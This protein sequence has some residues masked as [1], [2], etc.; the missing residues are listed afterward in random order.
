MTEMDDRQIAEYEAE[1]ERKNQEKLAWMQKNGISP[2]QFAESEKRIEA[3]LD[4]I[5]RESGEED[6]TPS[7]QSPAAIQAGDDDDSH[8][9][10]SPTP[11]PWPFPVPPQ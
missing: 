5:E 6:E 1:M 3:T 8:D 9:Q 7:D 4:A 2:E 11:P 10:G